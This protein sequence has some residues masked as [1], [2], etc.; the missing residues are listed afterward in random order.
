M[1][2][3][4]RG[5]EASAAQ[6]FHRT[7]ASSKPWP[8]S[9]EG[10]CRSWPQKRERFGD[11]GSNFFLCIQVGYQH[12]QFAGRYSGALVLMFSVEPCLLW[13]SLGLGL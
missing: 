12:V 5:D 10:E 2:G 1:S 3:I 8:S 13:F 6:L 7:W 4:V 11:L 9:W